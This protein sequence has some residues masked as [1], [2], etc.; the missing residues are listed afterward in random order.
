M[1]RVRCLLSDTIIEKKNWVEVVVY[2]MYTLNISPRTF[3]GFLTPEE[4]WSKYPPNLN[5]LQVFGCVGYV[6]QNQGKLKVRGIK[7]MF[8]VFIEGVKD[9]KM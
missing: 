6:H 9:F 4:K 5:D 3:V 8:V 7:C 1:E 2:A